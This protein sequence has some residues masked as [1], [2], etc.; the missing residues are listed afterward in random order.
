MKYYKFTITG[1]V[2]GVGFRPY[3]YNACKKARITGTVQNIGSGVE[4]I[5]D[6]R[7]DLSEILHNIPQNAR[8]D[9]IAIEKIEANCGDFEIIKSTGTGFSEI[10]AD[11]NLCDDCRKDLFNRDDRRFNYF[12]TTCTNCGPR[13]T[14]A[15]RSPYDRE[16]T[17]MHAFPMCPACKR[18]YTDP[19]DRRYHAQTI[20]CHS[21]GPGLFLLKDGMEISKDPLEAIK[22]TVKLIKDNHLIA[23]KGVGGFHIVCNTK[24]STIQK[25]KKLTNRT[26]KPFS[27]MCR[28]IRMTKSIASITPEEEKILLAQERSIVIVKKKNISTAISELDTVGIMLPYSA[29][30]ELLFSFYDEP[31]IM[32]S[33]NTSGA[34][35]TIDR[36]EQFTQYILDH[37]RIISNPT[38]D[39][40][41][42]VI[43]KK[44][45][46][47]RRS[48]GFV[49]QSLPLPSS[50][51][52]QILALGAEMNATFAIYRDGRV[53]PSQ[54]L[55]NT[56]KIE[57]FEHYKKTLMRFLD[58]TQ[59]KP[60]VLLADLHPSYNSSLYAQELSKEWN[61]PFIRIQHHHAH[62]AS[63]AAENF[64]TDSTAIVCDGLGYGDDGTIWGGE[65]FV[66]DQRVGHL[67]Q[68]KLLGGDSA[69]QQPL[70][71]LFSILKK[72]L[73]LPE[74][75]NILDAS[76]VP[77]IDGT[78]S[79]TITNLKLLNR[80]WDDDF[81]APPTSS[82][83]RILDATSVLLGFCTER[84]YDGRPAMILEAHSTTPYVHTP[85]IENDILLTT[86]LFEFL[87][88]NINKDKRR[89]AATAQ[90]YLAE[91]L[92]KIA[93]QY[94]KPITFSGGCTYNRIMSTYMIDHGVYVNKKIPPGDGGIAFG[95]IAYYLQKTI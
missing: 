30:H 88:Q 63:V 83:G 3:I 52:Q 38:D 12:F 46:L 24:V 50:S 79:S 86:P 23:I 73:S 74:I 34:P 82:C 4:I 67:E 32:T 56:A 8:I 94:N 15:N 2:Q 92:Y 84:T 6:K 61:I 70:K 27:L 81:N 42:K 57:T 40:L 49:P 76:I 39:S 16:T 35:I 1:T 90:T 11:L 64:L 54:F 72:F 9:D 55:G 36:H 53:T 33:A 62:A 28:D 65:V 20:A 14:I 37:S 68:Q 78:I 87:I 41:I 89:L 85:I 60:T 31:L 51:D 75:E 5:V 47:I 45:L 7:K 69:V 18:E 43:A 25:L 80:Q 22:K 77:S 21:C 10:P 48:R 19:T 95:Q 17:T 26:N 44:P 71:M 93:Q 59:T 66:N 58:Y 91:G 29:L 13:F